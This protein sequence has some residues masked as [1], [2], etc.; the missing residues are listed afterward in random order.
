MCSC[1]PA[2]PHSCISLKK[3]NKHNNSTIINNGIK[4]VSKKIFTK[5]ITIIALFFCVIASF[6]LAPP[7]ARI[8]QTM[9]DNV[10][11]TSLSG[12]M[13]TWKHMPKLDM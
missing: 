13:E 1:Y 7:L 8:T 4:Y 5:A 2:P 3:N 9:I 10:F 11:G 6:M 12:S